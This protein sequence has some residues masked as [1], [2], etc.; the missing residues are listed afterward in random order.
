MARTLPVNIL[1]EHAKTELRATYTGKQRSHLY[2]CKHEQEVTASTDLLHSNCVRR[3][4]RI[5]LSSG[6]WESIGETFCAR[7]EGE[8]R[9]YF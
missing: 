5:S 3:R 1:F 4:S 8:W 7:P 6:G 2:I 9:S